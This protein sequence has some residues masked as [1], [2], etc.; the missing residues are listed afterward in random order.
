MAADSHSSESDGDHEADTISLTASVLDYPTLFNRRYHRYKEGSYPFPNDEQEQHRMNNQYAIIKAAQSGR[1]FF[2]PIEDA[3]V[4]TNVLDVG[5]GTG[6]WAIEL[7]DHDIFP[8]AKITGIDLSPIQPE[9]VPENVFFEVQD[10]SDPSWERPLASFDLIYTR[11]L[12]GALQDYA[13][14]LITARKYLKPGQGWIECCE[15]MPEPLCDD[16]TITPQWTFA[17]WEKWMDHGSKQA[18]RPMRVAH[19]IKQWMIDAGYVDVHEVV[20]KIPIGS[21]PANKTLKEIGKAWADLIS[22]SLA[23]ASYKT[24]SEVLN[25]ERNNIELFLADTRH[26]LK[27]RKVHAYHKIIS[28]YGRRPSPEEEKNRGWMAPPPPPR[29]GR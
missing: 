9:E 18:G 24:M 22:D 19:N 14:Y 21:W 11:C 10:C 20:G 16:N 17:I 13:K 26:S 4:V 3:H 15:L 25:W 12:L 28:V 5:T 7:A 23:S 2:S 27:N 1:L 29:S 6:A 8:N